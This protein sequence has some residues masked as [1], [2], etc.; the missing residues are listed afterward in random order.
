MT[1]K[2]EK[3]NKIPS[4]APERICEFDSIC[5]MF[6]SDILYINSKYMDFILKKKIEK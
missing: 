4:I 1:T 6:I 3:R 5:L 2:Y